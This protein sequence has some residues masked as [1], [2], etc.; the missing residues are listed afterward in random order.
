MS[1]SSFLCKVVYIYIYERVFKEK[2]KIRKKT[3]KLKGGEEA[4]R[5]QQ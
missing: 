4:E 3:K 2:K 5:V 1:T